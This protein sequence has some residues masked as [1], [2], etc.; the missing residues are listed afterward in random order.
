ME[1]RIRRIYVKLAS[2][3]LA[4]AMSSTA[5]AQSSGDIDDIISPDLERR[6]IR[7]A[8]IDSEDFEFTVYLG[9]ILSVEDFGTNRMIGG[10]LAYHINED[11]FMEAAYGQATLGESSYERL[12]GS[13]PL[14]TEDERDLSMYNLSLAWNFLPGEIF[15]LDKFALNSNLYLIGGAGNTNFAGEEHFTYNV[16]VGVRMLAQDWLALRLDVRDHIFEHE[17]FGEPVNTN[18]LSAQLGVSI[19]F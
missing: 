17:I 11:F 18:N 1:T 4:G 15:I 13:A 9:G 5:L 19:Y 14:L 3:L 7:E 6:E 2:L 12:S 10:S 8:K 16:G